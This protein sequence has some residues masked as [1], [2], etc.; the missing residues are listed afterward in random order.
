[1]ITA[2]TAVRETMPILQ[3]CA[4][5]T[6]RDM[7][8]SVNR[9]EV[10]QIAGKTA[11]MEVK[12]AFGINVH[13]IIDVKDIYEYLKESGAYRDMIHKMEAYMEQY[14][15][16]L[17]YTS[18]AG[19]LIVNPLVS[20]GTGLGY[21]IKFG[22]RW[23]FPLVAGALFVPAVYLFYNE[24]ALVYAVIDA[25]FAAIGSWIGWIVYKNRKAEL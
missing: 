3:G 17:L 22:F 19:V 24:S 9:C 15:V 1:M 8:I 10:G 14:C 16:C 4:N 13:A 2:G 6:V 18:L 20:I 11:V 7:F 12:E 25:G 21:G 23:Y 5:V